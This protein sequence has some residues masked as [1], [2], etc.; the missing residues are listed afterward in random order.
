MPRFIHDAFRCAHCGRDIAGTF[1]ETTEV[2][3]PQ[4]KYWRAE[5]R[6]EVYCGAQCS[7]AAHESR[8]NSA[9]VAGV[10]E[11]IGVVDHQN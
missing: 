10:L 1:D 6:A 2:T 4:S 11:V 3:V 5:P 7:L 8:R 9:A